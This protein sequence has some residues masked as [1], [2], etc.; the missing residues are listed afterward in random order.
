MK[1]I[2]FVTRGSI[3]ESSTDMTEN[4]VQKIVL[5]FELGCCA[6]LQYVHPCFDK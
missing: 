1:N 2:Y 5:D 3:L 4:G 6:G